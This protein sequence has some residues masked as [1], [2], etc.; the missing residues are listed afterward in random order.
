MILIVLV[1]SL[2]S[3]TTLI[4]SSWRAITRPTMI[5]YIDKLHAWL[6]WC[7]YLSDLLSFHFECVLWAHGG[8]LDHLQ[9]HRC[10]DLILSLLIVIL[11]IATSV[12]SFSIVAII[13]IVPVVSTW[14]REE[15][16]VVVRELA[17]LFEW[18]SELIR[19]KSRIF[20]PTWECL[21]YHIVY[22]KKKKR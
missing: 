15:A 19:I 14:G 17:L 8:L 11:L 12:S 1:L 22:L 20:S 7:A 6:D 9:G 16:W 13:V 5:T 18:V 3:N 4:C 2:I 10:E 21:T